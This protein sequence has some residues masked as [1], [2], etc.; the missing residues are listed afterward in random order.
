MSSHVT[1]HMSAVQAVV[2]EAVPA[3]SLSHCL[4]VQQ[5]NNLMS[6]VSWLQTT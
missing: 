2:Q 4:L 1:S 5:A 3:R 6:A